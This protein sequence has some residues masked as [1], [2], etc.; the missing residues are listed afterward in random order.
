ERARGAAERPAGRRP[1]ERLETPPGA[2]VRERGALAPRAGGLVP[3]D[4]VRLLDPGV[5]GREVERFAPSGAALSA[6]RPARR[7]RRGPCLRPELA[8]RVWPP[9]AHQ[10]PRGALVAPAG[11]RVGAAD[12]PGGAA[13]C[14]RPDSHGADSR[15]PQTGR[16]VPRLH[17][18]PDRRARGGVSGGLRARAPP[19]RPGRPRCH[20]L[21]GARLAGPARP[22][23]CIR[24]EGES[25]WRLTPLRSRRL[26]ILG[27][28]PPSPPG[29]SRPRVSRDAP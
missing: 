13:R 29:A 22:W 15:P 9:E 8:V 20:A 25:P 6:R 16:R 14:A 7:A 19:P 1:G 26:R 10:R 5:A 12:R 27:Q 18:P 28:A 24:L 4:A 17:R 21:D 11:G 3:G 23:T 2:A